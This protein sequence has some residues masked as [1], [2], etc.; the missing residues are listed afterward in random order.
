MFRSTLSLL[1]Y[2]HIPTGKEFFRCKVIHFLNTQ[3]KL[4]QEKSRFSEKFLQAH[5]F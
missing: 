4:L 1:K 5:P 3:N 2:Q